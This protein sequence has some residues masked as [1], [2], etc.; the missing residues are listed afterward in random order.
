MI[1]SRRIAPFLSRI[2]EGGIVMSL[3]VTSDGELLGSHVVEE[4]PIALEPSDVGALVTEVAADYQRLGTELQRLD[5]KAA[6][7]VS[8]LAQTNKSSNDT[9]TTTTNNN[10]NNTNNNNKNSSNNK[11]LL[12]CLLIEMNEGYWVGIAGASSDTYVVAIAEPSVPQGLIKERLLT[13]S[14]HVK[15]SFSQIEGP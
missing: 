15:E 8:T 7:V 11:G 10:N 3:L 5:N 9:T 4:N 14:R 2:C 6:G 12:P 1:R 13:V